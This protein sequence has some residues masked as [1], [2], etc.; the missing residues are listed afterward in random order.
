[1]RRKL[2]ARSLAVIAVSLA[3]G[4]AVFCW[5]WASRYSAKIKKYEREIVSIESKHED[6]EH[7]VVNMA[8][9]LLRITEEPPRSHRLAPVG[10]QFVTQYD[11]IASSLSLLRT[12]EAARADS[13]LMWYYTQMKR[14]HFRDVSVL[15]NLSKGGFP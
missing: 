13:F 6:L 10:Y 4:S 11:S 12:F 1:M 3:V 8:A 9:L 7:Q 2:S 15:P 5:K 14:R